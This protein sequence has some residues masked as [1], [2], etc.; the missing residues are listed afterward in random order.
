[1]EPKDV[2]AAADVPGR[3]GW[4]CVGCRE[5]LRTTVYTQQVRALNLA[6]ALK[7]CG[8][9]SASTRVVVVGAGAAGLTVAGALAYLGASVTVLEKEADPLPLQRNCY[10][11]HLHPHIYDWPTRDSMQANAGLPLLTWRAGMAR[12]V[13]AA[14]ESG[15]EGLRWDYGDRLTLLRDVENLQLDT[16]SHGSL[17]FRRRGGA[18]AAERLVHAYDLLIFAIGFGVEET[19][20]MGARGSY[21]ADDSLDQGGVFQPGE[22]LV[23]GTGDGGLID[24]LRIALRNFR[25]EDLARLVEWLPHFGDLRAELLAIDDAARASGAHDERV[26]FEKYGSLQ[27]TAIDELDKLLRERH[28]NSRARVTLLCRGPSPF[29]LKAASLHRLLVSRL[30]FRFPQ[31]LDVCT[32]VELSSKM[33]R[34]AGAKAIFTHGRET[35]FDHVIIRHGPKRSLDAF[36]ELASY[37]ALPA[38]TARVEEIHYGDTFGPPGAIAWAG[39][40]TKADYLQ[41]L[42]AVIG[43]VPGVD[44]SAVRLDGFQDIA[45]EVR[46]RRIRENEPEVTDEDN[47]PRELREAKRDEDARKRFYGEEAVSK[48]GSTRAVVPL[49]GQAVT[50]YAHRLSGITFLVGKAGVGKSVFV[51]LAALHALKAHLQDND[52]IPLYV[53]R[54]VELDEAG[55]AVVDAIVDASLRSLQVSN[56]TSAADDIRT[57]LRRRKAVLFF[58]NVDD[59][60]ADHLDRVL[61]WLASEGMRALFSGRR[62]PASPSSRRPIGNEHELLGITPGAAIAFLER[63]F[64]QQPRTGDISIEDVAARVRK[65][66]N[67]HEWISSPFLLSRTAQLYFARGPA[68]FEKG[69]SRISLYAAMI[70]EGLERL[71]DTQR[72]S[73]RTLL[74]TVAAEDLERRIVR[75]TFPRDRFGLAERT[76]VLATGLVSG[77]ARLEFS[78][79]SLEEYLASSTALDLGIQRQKLREDADGWQH[80]LEIL[81]MAHAQSAPAMTAALVEAAGGDSDHRL[82][83]LLL[84]AI[85]YGGSEVDAFC[86]AHKDVVAAEVCNRLAL[87]GARFD[88][89]E[90]GLM[91]AFESAAPYLMGAHVSDA[92]LP[93]VGEPGAEAW[94]LETMLGASTATTD[95]PPNSIYWSTIFCQARLLLELS[96]DAV[97]DRTAG[98]DTFGR[99]IAL[100]ALTSAGV[101]L[102]DIRSMLQD[103]VAR[104]RQDT[105]STL[106][107][108]PTL[109]HRFIGMLADDDE[110]VRLRALQSQEKSAWSS[111]ARRAV[112]L[113]ILRSTDESNL[114]KSAALD[115][116]VDRE[117]DVDILVAI[118]SAC[119]TARTSS[120]SRDQFFLQGLLT[121]LAGEDGARPVIDEFIA[122]GR[123]WFC[124]VRTLVELCKGSAERRRLL[125]QRLQSELPTPHEIEA[126]AD[127]PELVPLLRDLLR[128]FRGDEEQWYRL[129]L[130]LKALPKND[131]DTRGDRLACLDPLHIP[132]DSPHGERRRGSIRFA[133]ICSFE[134]DPDA[135]ETLRRFLASD[136]DDD[137]AAAAIKTVGRDPRVR[138]LVWAR[139]RSGGRQ[140]QHEAVDALAASEREREELWG[141]M[142]TLPTKNPREA[143]PGRSADL[144]NAI[145]SAVAQY[146]STPELVS[147]LADPNEYVRANAAKQLLDRNEAQHELERHALEERSSNVQQVLW[148]RLAALPT[149]RARLQAELREDR[150][151][152]R[153]AYYLLLSNE[154]AR[155]PELR[156]HFASVR[157]RRGDVTDMLPALA[158]DPECLASL[159]GLLDA[160]DPNVLPLL[161]RV[162][163]ADP[164]LRRIAHARL[165]DRQ[166]IRSLMPW[167][168]GSF[169]RYFADDLEAKRLLTE[170]L[171]AGNLGPLLSNIAPVLGDYSPARALLRGHLADPRVGDDVQA[172]LVDEPDVRDGLLRRL[173][174]ESDPY[175]RR[176]AA[177]ALAVVREAQE[178]LALR[179]DDEEEQVRKVAHQAALRLHRDVPRLMTAAESD[180]KPELRLALV[181]GLARLRPAGGEELLRRRVGAD[182]EASVRKSAAHELGRASPGL[183]LRGDPDTRTVLET[184]PTDAELRAFLCAPRALQQ[185]D[186]PKLFAKLIAWGCAKLVSTM[187]D[188]QAAIPL[189]VDTGDSLFGE[190]A[191]TDAV[192]STSAV[193][194]RLA[195]DASELGRDRDIHPMANLVFAW[196]V[197]SFLVADE[198][199]SI[200]LACANTNFDRLDYPTPQ[201]GELIMGPTFFGFGLYES[202]RRT[203]STTVGAPSEIVMQRESRP[204]DARAKE[205]TGH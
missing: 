55:D 68:L 40:A 150:Y 80:H 66:P 152:I 132:E 199:R 38:G 154:P 97:V 153:H 145:V 149:V 169:E 108:E 128:R 151:D 93:H 170:Q 158:R 61:D 47:L 161:L 37:C 144:R 11:R 17:T 135:L 34:P 177:D 114:V 14:I 186:S 134:G 63:H 60:T 138:E 22:Y 24:V 102:K 101:A 16:P 18:G 50:P 174:D 178:A 175:E 79:L 194:L 54:R 204:A 171:A 143:D 58:D 48:L 75:L 196:D 109:L 173:A 172:A 123:A 192:A 183:P 92:A 77:G 200:V 29:S 119:T 86:A 122:S 201:P 100:R 116:L 52:D 104:V 193:R 7:A 99:L 8:H 197:L 27:G 71:V 120:S 146:R 112:I 155:L 156:A 160:E 115:L 188:D 127:F 39:G 141:Y 130:V 140:A 118:L 30:Y 182:R 107:S 129:L 165:G 65:L 131:A 111:D 168:G 76:A 110:W 67:G 25:Q 35:V 157:G 159:R 33:L 180:P 5:T 57:A 28:L 85:A 32:G 45:L 2:L 96:P 90:R 124:P 167:H 44:G 53:T 121:R 117:A 91:R 81:P 20:W 12:D 136:E 205:P 56:Y 89:A 3:C 4:Y 88:D 98:G 70:E 176:T 147:L 103:R 83:I 195:K 73:T 74:E 113:T 1:V 142:R 72:A 95:P 42:E 78:H 125:A 148:P 203:L 15:F 10:K 166:A 21:W 51:K 62:I 31:V 139:L 84:R 202:P 198:P 49:P 13:A 189:H 162:L 164:P 82:L 163:N 9:V 126:A 6:W 26:L 41:S 19:L 187:P 46:E 69:L 94:I 23:S 185:A 87:P 133:S 43:F 64:P 190:V 179:I 181:R 184:L 191:T 105:I 137:A 36:A 106:H 59:W